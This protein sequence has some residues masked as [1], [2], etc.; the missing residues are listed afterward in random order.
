MQNVRPLNTKT[1]ANISLGT[2]V[3]HTEENLPNLACK[4]GSIVTVICNVA[5]RYQWDES[6]ELYVGT[7][8]NGY[9]P[10][11]DIWDRRQVPTIYNI[12]IYISTAGGIRVYS[13]VGTLP[14][15]SGISFTITYIC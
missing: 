11:R 10:Y 15:N 13:N 14:A 5:N 12:G 3:M 6:R 2:D 9:A 4:S 7:L 8:P 1:Y